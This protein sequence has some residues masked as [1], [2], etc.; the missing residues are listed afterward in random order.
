VIIVVGGIKGGSGKTTIATNLTVMRAHEGYKVLL[1]DADEQLSATSWSDQREANEIEKP[2]VTFPCP[3]E[4]VGPQVLKMV[5]HYD[6]IIIDVG[7]RNT[8][9]QRSALVIAD[10]FLIP[11]LPRS[12]DIWTIGQV[13]T[14][15]SN[16][17]EIN[18]KIKCYAVINRGDSIGN[19]NRDALE[20]ISECPHLTCLPFTIG[21]RKAFANAA[22]DGLGVSELKISDK[23]AFNEMKT[24]YDY[25]YS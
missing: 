15:I 14:I 20:I 13:K 18:E 7:G 24:L 22:T 9:P 8:R 11:F 6:D 3:K 23:K 19:D 4:S 5:D 12:L 17:K 16:I 1:V 10:V 21:Q 2:W 25:V